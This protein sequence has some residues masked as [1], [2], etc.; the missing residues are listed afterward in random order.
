MIAPVGAER[1]PRT[2]TKNYL[3]LLLLTLAPGTQPSRVGSVGW[4]EAVE[5]RE[6]QDSGNAGGYDDRADIDHAQAV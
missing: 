6:P 4:M 2:G 3:A 5:L 1:E